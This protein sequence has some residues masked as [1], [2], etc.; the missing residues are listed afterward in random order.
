MENKTNLHDYTAGYDSISN[1]KAS[2]E[3]NTS[4]LALCVIG[5]FT[6]IAIIVC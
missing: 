1:L 5:L 3:V 2:K 4:A 6:L